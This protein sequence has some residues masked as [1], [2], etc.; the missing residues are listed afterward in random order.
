MTKAA[1]GRPQGGFFLEQPEQNAVHQ[2]LQAQSGHG[3][4]VAAGK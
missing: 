3:S 1:L 4:P 2:S